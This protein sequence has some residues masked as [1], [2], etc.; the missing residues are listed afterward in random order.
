[1]APLGFAGTRSGSGTD[2]EA[3]SP[4]AARMNLHVGVLHYTPSCEPFPLLADPVT[5]EPNT[6]D[7]QAD[8]AF[9][10]DQYRSA[11][12]PTPCFAQIAKL[13]KT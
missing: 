13:G 7:M 10:F 12:I 11:C 1:M 9:P 6:L 8:I 2:L 3:A 4:S 5:Y